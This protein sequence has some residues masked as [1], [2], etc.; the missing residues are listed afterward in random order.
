MYSIK[1]LE[2]ISGIKAHTLRIWERRYQLLIPQ[3]TDTNIRLYSDEQLVRLLNVKTLLQNNWKISKISKLSEEQLHQA[4]EEAVLASYR[5]NHEAL[6]HE[7]IR[8]TLTYNEGAFVRQL[9]EAFSK[10]G[11]QIAMM[12]VVYPFLS[13]VGLMWRVEKLIP[14]QEH[15]ASNIIRQKLCSAID[16]LPIKMANEQRFVLFLPEGEYHEIGLLLCHYILRYRGFPTFYLGSNVPLE[17]VLQTSESMNAD[18]LFLFVFTPG[19]EEELLEYIQKLRNQFRGEH[20]LIA[21]RLV[22]EAGFEL[23]EGVSHIDSLEQLEE[24]LV[25]ASAAS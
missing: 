8:H 6:V 14:A 17:N 10:L 19:P 24:L 20:I 13:K 23:P 4:I 18:Y 7:L 5:S 9:K 11:V 25:K 16:R 1:D 12:E 21:G 15:F 22:K 2:N 3:R